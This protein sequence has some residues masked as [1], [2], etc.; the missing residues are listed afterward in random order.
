MNTLYLSIIANITVYSVLIVLYCILYC[1][2]LYLGGGR[3]NVGC[4]IMQDLL[5]GE[6]RQG[7][8]I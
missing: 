7:V 5:D 8:Q 2:V 1:I 4:G 6:I 3:I